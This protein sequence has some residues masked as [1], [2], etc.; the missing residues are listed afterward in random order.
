MASVIAAAWASDWALADRS[1][2]INA[3]VDSTTSKAVMTPP[4]RP[5]AMVRSPAAVADGGAATRMV[6]EY[7]GPGTAIPSDAPV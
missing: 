4:A 2:T 5:T 3:A 6:I 1:T 7:P